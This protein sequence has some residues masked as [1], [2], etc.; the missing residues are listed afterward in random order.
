MGP[1]FI[2]TL[3]GP[4]KDDYEFEQIIPFPGKLVGRRHVAKAAAAAI[5]AK[6]EAVE[7]EVIFKISEAYYDLVTTQKTIALVGE[8]KSA[9]KQTQAAELS[10]YSTNKIMQS[11]LLKNQIA[12]SDNIR[13]LFVPSLLPE[14]AG[15]A[16]TVG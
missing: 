13:Q 16:V 4:I 11:E 5:E 8:I 15:C 12:I 1:S 3:N 9:L 7:R 2:E 14:F 6:M 10:R